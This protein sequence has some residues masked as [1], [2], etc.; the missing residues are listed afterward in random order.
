MLIPLPNVVDEFIRW[1]WDQIAPYYVELADRPLSAAT[2][3]TWLADWTQLASL[4]SESETRLMI[5]TTIN[6]ADKDAET[7]Y[8]TFLD[9]IKPPMMAA[10]QILKQKL[11]DSGLS[12]P[13]FDVPLRKMHVEAALF[14][15]A[16]V[17]LLT[18]ESK[19][20]VEYNQ[21]FGAQTVEWE[22]EQVPLARL[23]PA[24]Q[25]P[26]RATRERA[27]RLRRER[28]MADQPALS[29]L[30]TQFMDTRKQIALNAGF[31]D[32]R[33]YRWQQLLRLDY[34]PDDC[35]RFHAAI[36]QCVVPAASRLNDKRREKLGVPTLRPWD[37]AV[38]ASNR[39]ALHPFTESAD[40]IGKCE[41]IFQQVDPQLGDYFKTM[42]ADKLLDLDSR[43]GK[44][45][46]GYCTGLAV[47]RRPFIFM[48]AVGMHDDVQTLLHEAGHGFHFFEAARLPYYQQTDAPM[49]FCEV[50]SMAMELLAAPYLTTQS[51][52]FYSEV[53]AARAR[54]EHLQGLI[55]FWPYMS[56]VDLFQHWIYENH[57]TARDIEACNDKW[58][59]LIARFQPD[60]DRSGLEAEMRTI[61]QRQL[62][63][64]QL[65]FYYIEYGLAQLGATQI[66]ANA[67]HDQAG[68]VAAYRRGLALGGTVSLPELYAAAG[69]KFSFEADTL[70]PIIELI[71]GTIHDLEA[72]DVG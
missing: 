20:V 53:D 61:W 6:T 62:H 31:S 40:L 25:D 12:A 28:Q 41:T 16:N 24:L 21:I 39:P 48:N 5:A 59:E 57:D 65:P 3:E 33:A 67:L 22:G 11:L 38:D 9:T 63:I 10:E 36:E 4:L 56:V 70:C 69:A 37:M 23:L 26:D 30:W 60:I 51:G 50:A 15:E 42:D 52:G 14:R 18:E 68:A 34:A 54:L 47:K 49:E 19:L 29:A 7:H 43:T 1:P 64:F 66:W 13:N 8:K 72:V 44:G 2:V 71:E 27:W 32:Y 45:P 58:V 55:A 35:M 46:G 17:P